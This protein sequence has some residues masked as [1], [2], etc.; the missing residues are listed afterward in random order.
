MLAV[1]QLL[2]DSPHLVGNLVCSCNLHVGG[3]AS[4]HQLWVREQRSNASESYDKHALYIPRV[5]TPGPEHL[6][7]GEPFARSHRQAVTGLGNKHGFLITVLT[8]HWDAS[9]TIEN[10]V[11]IITKFLS[12]WSSIIY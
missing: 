4:H 11:S 3:E 8:A 12:I 10:I 6:F 1:L 9:H 2:L 5:L 7:C